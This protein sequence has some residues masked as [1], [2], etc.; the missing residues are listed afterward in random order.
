VNT[1]G[2]SQSPNRSAL[3]EKRGDSTKT[4]DKIG[5]RVRCEMSK[6]KERSNDGS[7]IRNKKRGGGGVNG[8]SRRV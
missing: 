8:L 5:S 2:V 4:S 1:H 3:Q 7:G 6:H